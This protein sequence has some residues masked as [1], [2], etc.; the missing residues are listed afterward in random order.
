MENENLVYSEGIASNE[1]FTGL[2]GVGIEP[3]IKYYEK[4]PSLMRFARLPI[5]MEN[6]KQIS[7]NALKKLIYGDFLD[8]VR[9]NSLRITG[10]M[11]G[12]KVGFSYEEDEEWQYVFLN[13]PVEEA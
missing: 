1:I 6:E 8:Y 12:I 7:R 9:Q 13:L 4:R 11:I 5:D 10:D 2:Y 3:P